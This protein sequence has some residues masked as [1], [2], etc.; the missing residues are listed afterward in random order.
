MFYL[1]Q[2]ED[3]CLENSTSDSSECMCV[4]AKSLQSCPI[5]CNPWTIA[6]RFLCPWDSPD[7]NT[8]VGCCTLLQV[9]VPTR[10][11]NPH[12]LS[13]LHLL[14]G[15]LPLAPPRKP[16]SSERLL[17]RGS[18]GRPICKILV[19]RGVQCNQALTL[20]EVFC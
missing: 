11:S 4:H 10:G 12:L 2:N 1:G 5:L 6:T 8:G 20:S 19:K 17:H 18:R 3:C 9:I 16:E 13:L 14:V 15:S 7:K